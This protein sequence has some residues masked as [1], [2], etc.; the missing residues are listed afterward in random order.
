[1]TELD[2]PALA[3]ALLALSETFNE[4]FSDVKAEAYFT[5]L[6]DLE[7]GDVLLAMRHALRVSKFFPRP[8]EIRE[9]IGGTGEDAAD[10]AWGAVI[11]EV[12]RVGYIG[13]PNLD[14]R[15]LLAVRQLW[16]GWV[17]LCE[18]LPAEG[19]ELVGWIKQFK[20]TYASV[21]KREERLLTAK[22]IHP[23]ALAF[24]NAEQKRIT[25]TT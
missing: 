4:P 9:S 24:I 23:N 1:M 10:A 20:A 19:P 16:G 3:E 11:R 5:A 22:T 12:W 14:E 15:T 6:S 13:T 17:R 25:E 8:A 21:G 7:I 2:R 18:T